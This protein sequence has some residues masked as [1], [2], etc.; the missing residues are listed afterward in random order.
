MFDKV[1][2]L[3]FSRSPFHIIFKYLLKSLCKA[4]A[5]AIVLLALLSFYKST[6]FAFTLKPVFM[7]LLPAIIKII[8]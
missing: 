8:S 7:P 3:L 6:G 1:L 2:F 5:S 4:I